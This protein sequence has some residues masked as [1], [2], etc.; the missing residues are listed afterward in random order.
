MPPKY[1]PKLLNWDTFQV[2]RWTTYK[3]VLILLYYSSKI[4]LY[5]SFVFLQKNSF[6]LIK[7]SEWILS[8]RLC[9]MNISI[10]VKICM[11]HAGYI[12]SVAGLF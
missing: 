2:S 4:S 1:I 10:I 12:N 6:Q 3:S 7:E 11:I 8:P 9:I 5:G